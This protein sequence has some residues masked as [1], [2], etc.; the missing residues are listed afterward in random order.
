M[1][2]TLKAFVSIDTQTICHTDKKKKK[3][4]WNLTKKILFQT[5]YLCRKGA[6]SKQSHWQQ[7]PKTNTWTSQTL[8][9]LLRK[10]EIN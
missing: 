6:V 1:I 4:D 3:K 2:S 9:K 5:L 10:L 7:P 8:N